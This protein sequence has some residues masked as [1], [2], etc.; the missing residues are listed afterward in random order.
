MISRALSL[1]VILPSFAFGTLFIATDG[2]APAQPEGCGTAQVAALMFW[3]LAA[4]AAVGVPGLL[5]G[6]R[7]VLGKP[8]HE[9]KHLV[10]L[11]LVGHAALVGVGCL[12]SLLG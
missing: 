8:V 10:G 5:A 3:A 2:F 12:R 7:L 9:L 6:A 1:L 4:A 11:A